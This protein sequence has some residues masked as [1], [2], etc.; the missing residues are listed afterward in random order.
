MGLLLWVQTVMIIDRLRTMSR[1]T[2]WLLMLYALLSSTLTMGTIIM[3]HQLP[4]LFVAFGFVCADFLLGL[5]RRKYF[6]APKSVIPLWNSSS[7]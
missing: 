1:G 5:F 2:A 6:I 3:K 7:L 4:T